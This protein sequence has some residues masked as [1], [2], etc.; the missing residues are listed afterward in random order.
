MLKDLDEASR[1]LLSIIQKG[2]PLEERPFT[3]LAGQT[4]ITEEEALR[5]VRNLKE[6]GIVVEI[7]GIFNAPAIGYSTTLVA[8]KV[9]PEKLD[10]AAGIVSLHPGVG[11]NY[12]READYNLWFTISIPREIDLSQEINS[13]QK[14]AGTISSLILPSLHLFKIGVFIEPGK[15]GGEA[16]MEGLNSEEASG[17]NLE[18]VTPNNGKLSPDQVKVI[19]GLQE[20]LILEMQPFKKIAERF[21]ME[22]KLF[23]TTARELLEKKIMRRYAARLPHRQLGFTHNAMI[24][25]NIPVI[26]RKDVGEKLASSPWVTHCYER[27]VYKEWPYALYS[28]IHGKSRQECQEKARTLSG[29]V[30]VKDYVLLFSPKEY[31]KARV[32]YFIENDEQKRT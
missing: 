1:K 25:W 23:L 27:P 8:M 26:N 30:G 31:K 28:M 21:G 22:E 6:R 14:K 13:L 4:N 24:C 19:K 9:A 15:N 17:A 11:H 10:E 20:D 18:G 3:V 32:K 29:Q 12:G 2:F 16:S 7:S 5:L